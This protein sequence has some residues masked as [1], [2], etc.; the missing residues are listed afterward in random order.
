MIFWLVNKYYR[1]ESHSFTFGLWEDTNLDTHECSTYVL[2]FYI[3]LFSKFYVLTIFSNPSIPDQSVFVLI[4]CVFCKALR[5]FKQSKLVFCKWVERP[6]ESNCVQNRSEQ[7]KAYTELNNLKKSKIWV[8]ITTTIHTFNA[9]HFKKVT[10]LL[11][12]TITSTINV[13]SAHSKLPKPDS[14]SSLKRSKRRFMTFE[15]PPKRY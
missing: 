1:I 2:Y 8:V 3:N 9:M 11:L 14:Q 7:M 13:K 15:T 5:I 6:S 10:F 12:N 4:V